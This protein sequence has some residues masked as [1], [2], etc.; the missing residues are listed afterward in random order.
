MN[1]KLCKGKCL[2]CDCGEGMLKKKCKKSYN[3]RIIPLNS[4]VFTW[5][6]MIEH[7][8]MWLEIK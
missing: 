3:K 5:Q 1:Y 7:H 8:A 6:E 2:M 4:D